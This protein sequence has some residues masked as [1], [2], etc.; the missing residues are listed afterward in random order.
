MNNRQREAEAEFAVDFDL[1]RINAGR[2]DL[3]STEDVDICGMGIERGELEFDF[4]LRDGGIL[5]R[6]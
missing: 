4:A 3:E 2:W 1:H 6:R 5:L